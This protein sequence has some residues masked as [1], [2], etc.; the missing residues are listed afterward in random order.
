MTKSEYA[1]M[2]Q[3]DESLVSWCSIC[4]CWTHDIDGWDGCLCV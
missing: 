3:V 4:D 2:F 1:Q